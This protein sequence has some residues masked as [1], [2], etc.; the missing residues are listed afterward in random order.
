MNLIPDPLLA[1]LQALPFLTLM[2]GLHFI[3]F[4]PMLAYLKERD[5]ATAGARQK[6]EELQE[7][8]ALKLQQWEAA[9]SRAEAEVADFRAQKRAEAQA[10]YAKK[11]AAARAEADARI[12]AALAEV[13]AEA[14]LAKASVPQMAR[15]LSVEMASRT[16]GRQ[17]QA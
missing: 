7:R 17:V 10:V 16:L 1:V 3:L 15:D 13:A 11:V 14:N 9:F 6:A 5:A 4:K 2:A 8:A 12:A